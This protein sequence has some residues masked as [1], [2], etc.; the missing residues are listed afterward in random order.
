MAGRRLRPSILDAITIVCSLYALLVAAVHSYFTN[1]PHIIAFAS[2]INPLWS[3]VVF[4]LC[5]L[6][7]AVGGVQLYRARTRVNDTTSHLRLLK[8]LGTRTQRHAKSSYTSPF[9]E[10]SLRLRSLFRLRLRSAE[11]APDLRVIQDDLHR[12]TIE[13]ST[14]APPSRWRLWFWRLQG[15]WVH[16]IMLAEGLFKRFFGPRGLF[17]R[18][19]RLYEVRLLVREAVILPLQLVRGVRLSHRITSPLVTLYGVVWACHCMLVLPL[20]MWNFY[21]YQC[22]ATREVYR[23]HRIRIL[24]LIIVLDLVLSVVV[25]MCVFVPVVYTLARNPRVL[26]NAHFSMHA[27]SVNETFMVTSVLDLLTLSVPLLLIYSTV[28]SIHTNAIGAF[29]HT[30]VVMA[31][32]VQ[33]RFQLI[34][35]LFRIGAFRPVALVPGPR[36]SI[37]ELSSKWHRREWWTTTPQETTRRWAEKVLRGSVAARRKASLSLRVMPQPRRPYVLGLVCT[38]V[39][40][41]SCGALVL[42]A[43]FQALATDVCT[44]PMNAPVMSCHNPLRPWTLFHLTPQPCHCQVVHVDCTTLSSAQLDAFYRTF[45]VFLSTYPAEYVN[46]MTFTN[47]S[48][49]APHR[50]PMSLERFHNLW[51]LHLD[52]ASLRNSDILPSL[53]AFPKL[54]YLTLRNQAWTELP[55]ALSALPPHLSVLALGGSPL[56]EQWPLWVSSAW[57]NLTVLSLVACDLSSL[58]LPILTLHHLTTLDLTENALTTLPQLPTTAW[59]QLTTLYLGGNALTSIPDALWSLPQLSALTLAANRLVSCSAPHRPL[60]L[61]TLDANPCCITTALDACSTSCAPL[62]DPQR[63]A[64]PVCSPYCNTVVCRRQFACGSD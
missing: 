28:Q 18:T 20:V 31:A 41:F 23:H 1:Q 9:H 61:Y 11:V 54:L 32:S 13:A 26:E 24:L 52:G 35:K 60:T 57:R 29:L 51:F 48:M 27:I 58:P 12:R 49:T 8:P 55:P 16:A 63:L 10:V 15:V 6:L 19:G 46:M 62:C 21:N 7:H 5:A 17:S 3:S 56:S 34:K 47:C 45:D 22:R 36:L 38:G 25:P 37:P 2:A 4:S 43:T 33:M 42:L 53:A 64:S 14:T 44:L 59:P 40:G 39:A 50:V 30:N